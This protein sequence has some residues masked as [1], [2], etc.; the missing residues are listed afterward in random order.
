[1]EHL[2]HEPI[3][4]LGP[5]EPIEITFGTIARPM[6]IVLGGLKSARLNVRDLGGEHD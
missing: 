3:H 2:P 1:M 4:F 5:Q 6:S